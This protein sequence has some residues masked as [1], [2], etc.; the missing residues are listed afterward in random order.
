MILKG[1]K[2]QIKVWKYLMKIPKGKV[3]T[4]KQVAIG[5]KDLNQ[6]VLLLMLVERTRMLLKC[7]ATEL[8]DLMEPWV[9][10]HLQEAQKQRK[11][12]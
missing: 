9:V 5:I 7:P 3:N 2:F 4:Y 11:N 6:L 8:L 12:S 1:T 10:F